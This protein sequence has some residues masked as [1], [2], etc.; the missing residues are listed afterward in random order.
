MYIVYKLAVTFPESLEEG[1]EKVFKIPN[2]PLV[3]QPHVNSLLFVAALAC[4]AFILKQFIK[5]ISHH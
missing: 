2:Y 4:A 5:C 3:A 1:R